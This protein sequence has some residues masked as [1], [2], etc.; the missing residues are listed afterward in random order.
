MGKIED[1]VIRIL[2]QISV[3]EQ[4]QYHALEAELMTLYPHEKLIRQLKKVIETRD[5]VSIQE[6]SLRIK[7]EVLPYFITVL[8]STVKDSKIITGFER[9]QQ[10]LTDLSLLQFHDPKN[11]DQNYFQNLQKAADKES[12]KNIA[13]YLNTLRYM[14][15]NLQDKKRTVITDEVQFLNELEQNINNKKY[16]WNSAVCKIN[17]IFNS[18]D[19]ILFSQR[20]ILDSFSKY[21]KQARNEKILIER[22]IKQEPTLQRV[23]QVA[24]TFGLARLSMLCSHLLSTKIQKLFGD[25]AEAINTFAR[26]SNNR[27]A[28]LYKQALA[29]SSQSALYDDML[30]IWNKR[31]WEIQYNEEFRRT[32]SQ[33]EVYEFCIIIIDIDK[34]K[35]VNDIYGHKA[36]D[37]ALAEVA[38]IIKE[39]TRPT[40]FIARYGGEEIS[41]LLSRT[42]L[43][44]TR[45]I[46]E[47]IR[48][49]VE[50]KTENIMQTLNKEQSI[51]NGR[52]NITVSIGFAGFPQ[53]GS[54]PMTLFKN[55]DTAL[56]HVKLNLGRN[57]IYA[58]EKKYS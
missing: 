9:I 33:K 3:D 6:I 7:T 2:S 58:F 8:K 52:K 16:D 13:E 28:M 20:D 38:R 48:K 56:R 49:N 45:S 14:W 5:K 27:A 30:E 34:F 29:K 15:G 24:R 19:N 55:A 37:K 43:E 18:I 23:K 54:D 10:E 11:L 44:E 17:D 4:N 12:I 40:D 35:N 26:R 53:D 57:K 31:A 1:E 39:S 32:T 42:N 25:K 22:S 51:A 41:I 47:R 50:E 21:L 46:A 36:G